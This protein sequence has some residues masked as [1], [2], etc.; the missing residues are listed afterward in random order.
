V[1]ERL[2]RFIPRE[3][4][5]LIAF[6]P[7]RGWDAIEWR[8]LLKQLRRVSWQL[9]SNNGVGSLCKSLQPLTP[10]LAL[11]SAGGDAEDWSALSA[12]ARREAGDTVLRL[13]FAQWGNPRGLFMDLRPSRFEVTH[14]QLHFLPNALW[15][16]LDDDFRTG[17]I[18]L[19]LGFYRDDEAL[20]DS[21]LVRMGFLHDGLDDSTAGELRE[22]LR[23]HFGTQQRRQRFAIDEFRGSFDALFEFF[24]EHDYRLRSDFVMVGF[25]LI[26]LYLT[27]E[28]LGA[29]HDVRSLCLESLNPVDNRAR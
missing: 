8:P 25:Y 23:A 27:L 3:L 19:Y 22:L 29:E 26:T 13:Y 28:E 4:R 16:Q 17:M 20:L 6:V 24:L 2:P 10:E 12:K 18:D 9:A 7:T 11:H 5:E 21:A 1:K 15:V 14:G